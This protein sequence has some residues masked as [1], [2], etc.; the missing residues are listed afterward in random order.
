[1]SVTSVSP[2]AEGLLV[3]VWSCFSFLIT[4]IGKEVAKELARRGGFIHMVCRSKDRGE[5]ARNEIISI[6]KN[7][8]GKR[9]GS[10]S[11]IYD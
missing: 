3:S 4:G 8:V 11:G 1:M 7:E 6:T 9:F 2:L 10:C 5:Q